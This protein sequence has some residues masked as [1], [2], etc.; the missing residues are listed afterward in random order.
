MKCP[1]CQAENPDSA[2]F[3]NNCGTKLEVPQAQARAPAEKKK[4]G[5]GKTLIIVAGAAVILCIVVAI[6]ASLGGGGDEA[7]TPTAAPVADVQQTEPP[8]TEAQIVVTASEAT[9][10]PTDT[11]PPP[12]TDTPGPTDT[13]LPT[14]TPVPPTATPNPD[15]LRPGTYIVGTDIQPGIYRGNAGQ[16]VFSSCYWARLKDLS[17]SIDALTAND[18]SL[19]QFYVEVAQGDYAFETACQVEL[20]RSLPEPPAEFPL[21]I[22]PGTY[23]V[24]HDIKPGLYK[25]QAGTQLDTCYWARL[26]DV[27]GGLNSTIANDNAIGPFYVEVTDGDYA[28]EVACEL[29]LVKTLPEPPAQFPQK[30]APGTYLVGIDIQPGQYRGQAGTEITDSCYWARLNDVRGGL[31]SIISND[32]AIGQYYVQVQQADFA[33]Q[34]EC[35]LERTGD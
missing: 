3:C 33:L 28:F 12:P 6:L 25:G 7:A 15:L 30:I 10:P 17:G 34:T 1:N 2:T 20:L 21:E 11:A 23:L 26:K 8:P 5:I 32:N 31:N 16:G 29:A 18:N 13:P 19:G 9:E 4:R 35:E 22:L 27:R 24:G 14:N